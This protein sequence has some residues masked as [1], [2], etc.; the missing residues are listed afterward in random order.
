MVRGVSGV[1]RLGVVCICALIVRRNWFCGWRHWGARGRQAGGRESIERK[2]YLGRFGGIVGLRARLGRCARSSGACLWAG[3]FFIRGFSA[4]RFFD[5]RFFIGD[6]LLGASKC[7][8]NFW[9]YF[10]RPA[11]LIKIFDHVT[12]SADYLEYLTINTLS[13]QAEGAD[14]GSAGGAV[15]FK[16]GADIAHAGAAVK[17]GGGIKG[18]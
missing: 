10:I 7:G 3:R 2:I 5:G 15:G 6:A 1:S 9:N 11:G 13:H 14:F 4:W 17:V 8:F 18:N 16:R 12:S